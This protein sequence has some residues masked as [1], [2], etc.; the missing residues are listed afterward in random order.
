MYN[1]N[2]KPSNYLEPD[3]F[4]SVV[5]NTPLI[6]IDLVVTNN[7]RVLLGKRINRPAKDFFLFQE[8]GSA[9]EKSLMRHLVEY[10]VAS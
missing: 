8:E 4:N 6:A 2:M 10:L 5:K 9:R 3:I 1:I 7:N